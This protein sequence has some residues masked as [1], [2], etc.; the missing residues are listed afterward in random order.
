MG[1]RPTIMAAL[2]LSFLSAPAL[3]QRPS[4][5]SSVVKVEVV[6]DPPDL[7]APWQ[8]EGVDLFGGSGVIIE[9]NRVLT[10]AHVVE[11]AVSI[12]VK[13][14]D[15]SVRFP[16]RVLHI[17][18][19]ADLALLDV[20][21][22]RF[23]E[24]T[25]PVP[26]GRMPKLLQKVV[27]YGFPIGGNTLSITSG[28]VSRIEVD[29]YL[30]S[31]RE[32]LSVQIDAAINEG[33]SGGPVM[34]DGA[35]V[36]IAMQ[37]IEGADNVGYMIPPPVIQ[38]F[39]EDVKDGRYDGFPRLGVTLQEMGSVAQRRAAKMSPSQSGAL[40]LRVDYG[41]PA[42]G[43]LRPRD[44][45]LEI[46]GHRVANDLTI[47]WKGVGRVDLKLA[48]QTKQIGETVDV[49][50]LRNGQRSK[51]RL[52]LE[53]HNPLVPGRRLTEWPRYYQFGGLLFQPLSEQLIDDAD[54]GYSD[55][56]TFA[57]VN[58]LVTK[59]RREIILLGTVLPHP[60]NRGY[61]DWGGEVI[62]LVNGV[63]PR[64]L[65]HLASLI[66]RAKGSWLRIV[67]GDGYLITLDLQQARR[68]N[69]EILLD[70]GI[71]V[72]RYLGPGASKAPPRRRR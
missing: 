28:I 2:A 53:P 4:V 57:E 69:K 67:T 11:G 19:D 32:L 72:D 49:V 38:H 20:Q 65:E 16:A 60:V 71:P 62:R 39:L 23:F 37:D 68:A 51:K 3:A 7:L 59:E 54:A 45:I 18:H 24:G 47:P 5:A 8:T 50:I 6:A 58:N 9:G 14:A 33:N 40:V 34:T 27:V 17:S 35:I 31:Y 15:G 10:N 46:D 66:D 63:V 22:P 13:R 42:Y 25:R 52:K 1:I 43:V 12:D 61:Q 48:Y 55:A 56:V 29:M 26:I 30:Q 44:V 70:Y 36:G 21:E 64:D 41:G